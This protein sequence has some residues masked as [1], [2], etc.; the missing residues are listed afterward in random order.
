MAAHID[1]KRLCSKAKLP[2]KNNC[3]DA[4]WD[5]YSAED[6]VIK[7]G[8]RDIVHTGIAAQIPEGYFIAFCDRS[9]LA[10]KYGLH[11]LAGVID[12]DYRGEWLVV[13]ANLGDK[14]YRI[15]S[16]D[17]IAQAI[18][19]QVYDVHLGEAKELK[20]TTRGERGFG[21]SGR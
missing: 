20:K 13:L 14:D 17:R 6:T 12:S 1:I 11:V 9:G 5:I 19:H 3:S 8:Q 16:G 2:T 4:G 18:L 15:M 10:A 7:V 21:S